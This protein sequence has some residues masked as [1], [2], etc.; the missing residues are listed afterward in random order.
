MPLWIAATAYTHVLATNAMGNVLLLWTVLVFAMAEQRKIAV[1]YVMDVVT[2]ARNHSST[3]KAAQ[4]RQ[5][6]IT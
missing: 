3:N 4:T 6:A 1:A 2:L 5:L